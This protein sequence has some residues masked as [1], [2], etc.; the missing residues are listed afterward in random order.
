[1]PR[2]RTKTKQKHQRRWYNF[3][4]IAI[5]V[6]AVL[7][8]VS[9]FFMVRPQQTLVRATDVASELEVKIPEWIT[10]SYQG[11]KVTYQRLSTVINAAVEYD[12]KYPCGRTIRFIFV[13]VFFRQDEKGQYY[14]VFDAA[15]SGKIYITD[16]GDT[17]SVVLHGMHHACVP[18]TERTLSSPIKTKRGLIMGYRGTTIR[19]Q[20]EDGSPDFYGCLEEGWANAKGRT[21]PN[22]TLNEPRY[23]AVE[24]IVLKYFPL[25]MQVPQW[26]KTSDIPGMIAAFVGKDRALLTGDDYDR[27]MDECQKAW[28]SAP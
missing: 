2:G 9:V 15:E 23:L 14:V 21:F 8:L 19:L 11:Q 18:D 26:S 4:I 20:K 25:I 5:A 27:I 22:F 7:I 24:N 28:D 3:I 13:P 6:I 1:M 17:R 10:V 12:S 16:Q